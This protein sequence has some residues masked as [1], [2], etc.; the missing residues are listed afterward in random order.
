VDGAEVKTQMIAPDFVSVP[1]PAGTHD[2]TFTYE[3]Y[4]YYL[5]LLSLGLLTLVGLQCGLRLLAGRS[6][7]LRRLATRAP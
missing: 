5:E 1:V 3:P 6:D 4:P 7:W 2:V